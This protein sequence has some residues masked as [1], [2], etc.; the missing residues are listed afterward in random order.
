MGRMMTCVVFA[1]AVLTA[2]AEVSSQ[3][4]TQEARPKYR[5]VRLSSTTESPNS[6]GSGINN[7]GL[8]AGNVVDAGPALD[9]HAAIW[10]WGHRLDLDPLGGP[11]SSVV[12]PGRNDIGTVVGIAQTSEPEAYGERWSCAEFFGGTH[13]TGYTCL[14][15][16]W[17][18]GQIRRLPTLGGPNGFAA[19]VNNLRQIVGWAENTV[20]D[21]TCTETQIFQFHGVL[22]G[23]GRHQLRDLRPFGEDSSSAATAI[24]DRGQIVG[25]SGDCDRAVGR[26]SARHAVVWENGVARDLGAI[27]ADTWNTPM[28][29]NERG[30]IVGFA[31]EAG[32]D[33]FA[34]VL[35][36]VYWPRH[37]RARP[38]AE[39]DTHTNGRA[40]AINEHGQIAGT[41]CP[42]AGDCSAVLWTGHSG[43]FDLNDLV[44]DGSDHLENAQDI[45]DFGQITG[46]AIDKTG[47]RYAYVAVPI[48]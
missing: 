37:G 8:V 1:I 4:V 5:L 17:E 28:A 48:R 10:L 23:P 43:P 14:G 27:G 26:R 45:N 13:R 46:R 24:N 29:L 33:P 25:I 30:E 32:T 18:W 19:G 21:D 40:F 2:I 20:R 3:A 34:P 42:A 22:W 47:V 16:V 44:P 12:W 38:L 11:N 7:L 15:F 31:A 6:R 9:R 36:A 41:S 35:H 39:L